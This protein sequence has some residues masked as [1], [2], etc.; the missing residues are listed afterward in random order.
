MEGR[1]CVSSWHRYDKLL[2]KQAQPLWEELNLILEADVAPEKKWIISTNTGGTAG[3]RED[4][5]PQIAAL[6]I[7]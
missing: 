3:T 7:Q 1:N 2:T 4:N 5:E 6:P